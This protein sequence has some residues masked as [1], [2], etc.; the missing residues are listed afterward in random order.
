MSLDHNWFTEA[1]TRNGSAF[2]LLIKNKL[3]EEQTPYQ[4]LEIYDTEKF[5]HLMVL[6]G[7]IML[8]QRDNF[9]Y[10]EMMTHPVLFS[11]PIPKNILIIGGGDCGTLQQVLRHSCVEQVTQID[12]DERVTRAAEKFFPEL[13]SDNNDPRACLEFDDGIEWIKNTP[14]ESL[15]IIIVDSTDPIGPAQGLFNLDFHR[16]C[17]KALR[18]GGILIQQSESPLL[19]LDTIL[20]P[21]RQNLKTAG[22]QDVQSLLFPQPVY[23]SG[24]WSATLAIKNSSLAFHREPEAR[25]KPFQTHYYNSEIH[26]AAF[27]LPELMINRHS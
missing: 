3:H 7:Y 27:A 19:H 21:L 4:K 23:P 26:K 20:K 9:L 22:F 14:S 5:G 25:T 2:S 12:I 16:N 10:H 8:T 15:D 1:D 17:L 6:D 11:H 18:S 24:W 13:C